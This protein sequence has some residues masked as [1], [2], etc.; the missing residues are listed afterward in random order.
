MD[1]QA[2]AGDADQARASRWPRVVLKGTVGRGRAETSFA[3]QTGPVWSFGPLSIV[4]PVFDG[5]TRRANVQAAQATY[6]ATLAQYAGRLRT[7]VRE[8]E[9][10]LVALQ[11]AAR[12]AD[13]VRASAEGFRTSFDSVHARHQGGM[14]SLFELEDARRSDVQAR[15]ALVDLEQERTQAWIQLYRALGGG[16]EPS[17]AA[18]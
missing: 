11:G 1:V 15:T 13:D 6:D 2:A 4:F 12:R 7:A 8:T 3:S 16:W 9:E 18:H 17:A 14:A 5:G 10:A